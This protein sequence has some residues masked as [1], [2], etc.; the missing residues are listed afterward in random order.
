MQFQT[1]QFPH[2]PFIQALIDHTAPFEVVKTAVHSI[3]KPPPHMRVVGTTQT[4]A[5]TQPRRSASG[6]QP[7]GSSVPSS[8][9]APRGRLASFL[10][11]AQSAIMKAITFSC[12]QNHYVHKR[13]I[14]SKNQLKQCLRD[15]GS[16]MSDDDPIPAALSTSTFGFPSHDEYPEFFVE[17]DDIRQE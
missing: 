14:I 6:T 1:R 3:W 16:P 5:P 17:H 8:S 9:S 12:Q 11:K 15:R 13:L 2:A 7:T 10:G 4:I